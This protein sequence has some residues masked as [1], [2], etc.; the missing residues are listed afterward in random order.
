MTVLLVILTFAL[1]IALDY[2]IELRK[3][4]EKETVHKEQIRVSPE[5]VFAPGLAAEPVWVAGYQLPEE[6]HYHRGHTWARLLSADTVLIGLDDF[7][8]KLIG[9]AKGMSDM[10]SAVEAASPANA[11]GNLCSS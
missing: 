6:L 9:P 11:S 2:V 1:F 3:E 8:S 10:V 7:A 4:R 5:P